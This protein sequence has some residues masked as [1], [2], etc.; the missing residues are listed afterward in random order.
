[1]PPPARPWFRFYVE[2]FHDPKLRRLKPSERWLW[3]AVLGVARSSCIS[4]FLLVSEREAYTAHDLADFAAM[5]EREVEQA[6]AK[7]E[8]VG[9]VTV[10]PDL[11]CWF[12]PRWS[13][14][15]YESD[16]VTKRTR[17]HRSKEPLR[18]VPT[19]FQ[20]TPPETEADTET[21]TEIPAHS[22]SS[23][24]EGAPT[25]SERVRSAI[26]LL[27]D[28]DVAHSQARNPRALREKCYS[29]RDRDHA[30]D[31]HRLAYEHEDWTPQQLRDAVFDVAA[32]PR[33][34]CPLCDQPNGAA[35]TDRSCRVEQQAKAAANG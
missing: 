22:Q 32:P 14:R 15:Q 8:K 24:S 35:H 33:N 19:S 10:D 12:V 5:P 30:A 9:L 25:R 3:C 1:M 28:W 2:A 4:G 11:V 13:D 17:K 31:L 6:M 20:G 34:I 18:N 29:A 16:D 26:G 27:A 7:F 21:E 23:T